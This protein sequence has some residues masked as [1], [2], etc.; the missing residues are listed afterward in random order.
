MGDERRGTWAN[1]SHV[2]TQ[3]ANMQARLF[4]TLRPADDTASPVICEYVS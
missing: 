2:K 4:Y 3:A 1:I